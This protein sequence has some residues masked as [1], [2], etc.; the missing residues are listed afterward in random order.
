MILHQIF[1]DVRINLSAE[2]TF[3]S[4]PLI[5]FTN[6]FNYGYGIV[7]TVRA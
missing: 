7:G 3:S 1:I 2:S 6:T 4:M 5:T